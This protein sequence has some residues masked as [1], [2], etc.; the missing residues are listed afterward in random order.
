MNPTPPDDRLADRMDSQ[1]APGV[2][3]RREADGIRCVACAHRCLLL[4]GARGV[5]RVRFLRDG[6][7]RVPFGYVAGLACDPI[8]KKPFFHVEPGSQALTFGM[9]GCNFH[10][11]F[12]QNWTSSQVLRDPAA[13][14]GVTPVSP[15]DVL[16][17]A[18]GHGAR[19]LISSYNEPV[20]TAEWAA[21]LFAPAHEA[22][23]RCG[24]VSNG[25]MTPES[26]EFLAPWLD[27]CKIDLKGFD[28]RRYRDLGGSLRAVTDTLRAVHERGIWLEVVTLLA[29][30]LNDSLDE[31]RCLARFLVS[32]SPDI[33][34]HVTGFHP[35]YRRAGDNP[36]SP[37]D[38][39][40]AA[41]IGA[42]EGLRY[43][44]TGN[45][46]GQT[47]R[48]ENTWCPQCRALL[49]ER[50]GYRIIRAALDKTGR[51]PACQTVIPGR[52]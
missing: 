36:T 26:L 9:L 20:I 25:H 30:G 44:Y 41:Q 19:S 23:L 45:R 52:W 49:V 1:T 47:G 3:W 34:W 37:A 10:C 17:A 33:P 2:L 31:L 11:D 7:L 39:A 16:D 35:V 12:C 27:L 8:E 43:V 38:L 32:L 24:I 6:Q 22:G 15:Q 13:R 48:W 46:P 50:D 40:R 14:A 18:L 42:D 51:C 21:A 28:E 4:E 5:C 29:P